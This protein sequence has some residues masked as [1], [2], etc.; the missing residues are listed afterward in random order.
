[1]SNEQEKVNRYFQK[2]GWD[3]KVFFNRPHW[4]RRGFSDFPASH[5]PNLPPKSS[6][7]L[8]VTALATPNCDG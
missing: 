2:Y 3:R 1:M 7:C 8:P 6:A 4:T 5:T